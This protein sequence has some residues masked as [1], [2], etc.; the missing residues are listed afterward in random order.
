MGTTKL[1]HEIEQRTWTL[2]PF[3]SNNLQELEP[4]LTRLV[5]VAYVYKE[6]IGINWRLYTA[7]LGFGGHK[8]FVLGGPPHPVMVM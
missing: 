6:F 2:R 7:I 4:S 8:R 5:W 1:R 3:P